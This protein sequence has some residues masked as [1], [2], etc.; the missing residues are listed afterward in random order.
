MWCACAQGVGKGLIGV[1]VRPT[2]GIIDFATKTF[3]GAVLRVN[4][5]R[6]E[7]GMR[8]PGTVVY[9]LWLISLRRKTS[10]E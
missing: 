6:G 5:R 1:V 7:G 2:A 4:E 9:P 3:E 8:T 10:T